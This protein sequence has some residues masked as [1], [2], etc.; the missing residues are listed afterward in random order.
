MTCT[1]TAATDCTKAC[2]GGNGDHCTTKY[3]NTGEKYYLHTTETD[4][5]VKKCKITDGEWYHAD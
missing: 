1:D 4:N 3:P 5:P 2:D